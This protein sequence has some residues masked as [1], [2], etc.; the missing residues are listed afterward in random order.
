MSDVIASNEL[1]QYIERI[2]RITE[3]R[4][5]INQQMKDVYDEAKSRGFDVKIMKQLI[6]LRKMN[7]DDLAN[8]D[9][10]LELYRDALNI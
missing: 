2:E 8:Q 4:A 10:M 3:D 9:A 6:K 1:R 5:E 7:K